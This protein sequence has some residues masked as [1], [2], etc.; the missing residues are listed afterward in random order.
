MTASWN[1]TF[2]SGFW[3]QQETY[4]YNS[5]IGHDV[6]L[7][8]KNAFGK[9]NVYLT[10]GILNVGDRGPATDS[11]IPGAAGAITTLDSLRGRTFFLTT[12]MSF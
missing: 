4:R 7:R 3:N 2:V 12:K 11:T 9:E 1:V 5:W 6:T 10:T 8:W